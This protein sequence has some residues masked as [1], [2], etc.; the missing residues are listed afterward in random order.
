MSRTLNLHGE[1]PT[2][3]QIRDLCVDALNERHGFTGSRTVGVGVDEI[4]PVS[5]SRPVALHMVTFGGDPMVWV[6]DESRMPIGV[7]ALTDRQAAVVTSL[8]QSGEQLSLQGD[9]NWGVLLMQ[10]QHAPLAELLGMVDRREAD[11]HE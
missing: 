7:L 8:L 10:S 9:W 3:E 11:L 6:C 1:S 2:C 4:G 5:A